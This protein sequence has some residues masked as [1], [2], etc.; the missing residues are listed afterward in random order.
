MWKPF[1]R[2]QNSRNIHKLLLCWVSKIQPSETRFRF[3]TNAETFLLFCVIT[4]PVDTLF[5]WNKIVFFLLS[6]LFYRL[7]WKPTFCQ[8]NYKFLM[9]VSFLCY[10]GNFLRFSFLISSSNI[11]TNR[12]EY[13]LIFIKQT[14]WLIW[15]EVHQVLAAASLALS[16]F[17]SRSLFVSFQV[18]SFLSK[19]LTKSETLLNKILI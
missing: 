3:R 17:C 15:D 6:S 9:N 19:Y 12:L 10:D 7:A 14:W 1:N 16:I 4:W 18:R 2:T 8:Q 5:T 11:T 13:S